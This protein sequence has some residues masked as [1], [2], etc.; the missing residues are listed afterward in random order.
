MDY[1]DRVRFG[2]IEPDDDTPPIPHLACRGADAEGY[3]CPGVLTLEPTYAYA[4]T[5][6]V[7]PDSPVWVCPVCG[8]E[9]EADEVWD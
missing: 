6:A 3:E 1:Q 8:R 4:S 2:Y 9:H 7:D 5:S